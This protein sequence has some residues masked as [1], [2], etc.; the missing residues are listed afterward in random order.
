[1]SFTRSHRLSADA[2]GPA[3]K[4]KI[5]AGSGSSASL[6]RLGQSG[7]WYVDPRHENRGAVVRG[8]LHFVECRCD[9]GE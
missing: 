7:M 6:L 3:P 8:C 1:M 9:T 4:G 2:R 5:S